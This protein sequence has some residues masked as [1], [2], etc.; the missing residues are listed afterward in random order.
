MDA[1]GIYAAIIGAHTEAIRQVLLQHQGTGAVGKVLVVVD[2][3][4][5]LQG[6]GVSL[7][8]ADALI[9][10]VSIA[11]IIG[12]VSRDSYMDRMDGEY[13]GYGFAKHNGYGVP[14]HRD[15]LQRLGVCPIHRRSYAPIAR[16]LAGGTT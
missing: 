16:L 15:A 5:P 3:N 1:Q 9:P 13:P 10:A 2:G 12:K 14:A 4:L 7:P 11:S 6:V 8:K